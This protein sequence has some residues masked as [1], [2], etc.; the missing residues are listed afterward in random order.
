MA[1]MVAF[2]EGKDRILTPGGG[3]PAT[4]HFLLS[5]AKIATDLAAPQAGDLSAITTYAQRN[6][7]TWGGSTSPYAR[8]SISTPTPS[9]GICT[10]TTALDWRTGDAVDGPPD[11]KS[12]IALD[13]ANSKLL[14]AW[15][16]RSMIAG[17]V[18]LNAAVANTRIFIAQ[19]F[20]IFLQNEDGG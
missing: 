16:L 12:L 8:K 13:N 7:A 17:G 19:P 3:M 15:D 10:F 6:E 18:N 1:V 9:L 11:I 20:H 2:N 5:R 4:T 14:F